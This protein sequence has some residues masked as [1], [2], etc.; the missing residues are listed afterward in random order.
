[1]QFVQ[2]P[3][4]TI[5]QIAHIPNNCSLHS[6]ID[7]YQEARFISDS[8]KDAIDSGVSASDISILTKQQASRNTEV[9]RAEL[10]RNGIKNLDMT[11]L[12]DALKE[13]LGQLFTLFLKAIVHPEPQVMTELFKVNLALNKVDPGDDKE[14]A[15]TNSLIKFIHS[16]FQI[17]SATFMERCR[18]G[19]QLLKVVRSSRQRN[20]QYYHELSAVDRGQKISDFCSFG[21]GNF[22]F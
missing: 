16:R 5:Q 15:L 2:N 17:I 13:P 14:E 12:Q 20:K 1:M 22:G 10:T 19:S 4:S 3:D 21:T 8:I 18:R 6:F 11:D 7:E 9:L